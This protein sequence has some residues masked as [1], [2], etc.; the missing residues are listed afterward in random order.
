MNKNDY[1]ASLRSYL[2]GRISDAEVNSNIDYYSAYI[3]GEVSRGRS[4][5]E[6]LDEL[7]DPGLIART[8]IDSVKR[9]EEGLENEYA[10]NEDG[11]YTRMG[12]GQRRGQQSGYDGPQQDRPY[13]EDGQ[14]QEGP[15][16]KKFP[17]FLIVLI[18]I[19][20]I[21]FGFS[22]FSSLFRFGFYILRFMWPFILIII[23]V[24]LFTG[25]RRR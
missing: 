11:S 13:E 25:G 12:N 16:R 8:L 2:N 23:L 20:V 17:T 3:D 24:A 15:A 19:L 4:E 7:G 5:E 18:I 21:I 1:L 6:V 10:Q 22:I 9:R 14:R